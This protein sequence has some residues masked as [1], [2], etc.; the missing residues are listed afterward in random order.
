LLSNEK[1]L[2]NRFRSLWATGA[3]WVLLQQ[4]LMRALVGIKFLLIARILGPAAVGTVGIA[5]LVLSIAEAVSDTGIVQAIVQKPSA[6]DD[7]ELGAAWSLL[8]L[9]GLGIGL[10]IMA[11]APVLSRQFQVPGALPLLLGTA[12]VPILRGCASPCSAIWAR[13]RQFARVALLE[14]CVNALDFMIAISGA[15]LG[16]G[17]YA[18]LGAMICAE[19]FRTITLF[20]MT[21]PA[22]R[23]NLH[24]GKIKDY[25]VYGRWIWAD[26]VANG[27][28]LNQFDR[29]IVGKWFGPA[30]LG[31]YQMTSK[32]AQMLLFDLL[33]AC[34]QYLFPTFSSQFRRSQA[35]AYIAFRRFL[36][37]MMIGIA[38]VFT[39]AQM[40]AG[41]IITVL[42]G[43][44]WEGSTLIFRIA[45]ISTAFRGLGTVLTAYLRATGRPS[46]VTQSLV[47][48]ICVLLVA[49]PTGGYFWGLN[50]V[51]AGLVPGALVST[52]WMLWVSLDVYSKGRITAERT[53]SQLGQVMGD[54]AD[55]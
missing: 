42:L 31:I 36:V 7:T 25:A 5:L 16:L 37:A 30:S 11:L 43:P 26:S 12:A 39:Y 34:A 4:G 54:P 51:V 49:V 55:T 53:S 19:S 15:L 32:L 20:V 47:L 21:R 2:K 46:I 22:V 8:I 14:I 35:E 13:D 50:G 24:L 52:A 33:N 38:V 40:S 28:L 1:S 18:I 45:L 29:I 23:P 6:P 9:R 44:S 48:Q 10:V 27:L 17:V 41:T 3:I